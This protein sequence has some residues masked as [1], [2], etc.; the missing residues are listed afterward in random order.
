M[1]FAQKKDKLLRFCV[2]YRG[3]N[4]IT[5]KSKYLLPLFDEVLERVNGATWFF[6]IDLVLGY[7]QIAV[8]EED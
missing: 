5:R 2:D 7:H 4:K 8:K 6:K 3:L 1:F